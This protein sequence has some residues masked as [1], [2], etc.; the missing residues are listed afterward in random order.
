[1]YTLWFLYHLTPVS[2]YICIFLITKL[3]S[4]LNAWFSTV[5]ISGMLYSV[6]FILEKYDFISEMYVCFFFLVQMSFGKQKRRQ[7]G[8]H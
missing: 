7:D 4:I 1:M 3:K 2:L 5:T 6:L 8:G